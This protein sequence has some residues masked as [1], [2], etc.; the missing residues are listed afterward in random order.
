MT[1]DPEEAKEYLQQLQVTLKEKPDSMDSHERRL[2]QNHNEAL[3]TADKIDQDVRTIQG[4]IQQANERIQA[5]RIDYAD[6]RGKAAGLLEGIL[7][8]KFGRELD[9]AAAVEEVKADTT[10]SKKKKT[11]GKQRSK[12]AKKAN[13]K[14]APSTR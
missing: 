13:S 11:P 7:S 10:P 2:L 12:N 6:V 8:Y 9:E 4:Q 5:A 1:F 14:S 3:A